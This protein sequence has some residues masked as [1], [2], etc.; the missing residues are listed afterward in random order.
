MRASP[1]AVQRLWAAAAAAAVVVGAAS[2]PAPVPA[3]AACAAADD[4]CCSLNGEFDA[5]LGACACFAPWTGAA[6]GVLDLLP[7]GLPQGYGMNPNLTSWGASLF[8]DPSHP[9]VTH[10][11]VAESQLGCSLYYWSQNL[12][13]S[14]AVS[15]AGPGAVYAFES[16]A[17][18]QP[19][20][21]PEVVSFLNATTGEQLFALFHIGDGNGAPAKNCSSGAAD[22]GAGA[23]EQDL[24]RGAIALPSSALTSTLHIASSPYGPWVPSPFPPPTCNNPAP[25]PHPNGSF[26]LLCDSSAL[27][28]SPHSVLGPWSRA[29]SVSA[30]GGVPGTYE[31]AALFIDARGHWH[32]LFHVYNVYGLIRISPTRTL[33]PR[34][35]TLVP[36]TRP[37]RTCSD[38]T[39]SCVN[40]TVSGHAFSR[41]GLVWQGSP[42]QPFG[43]LVRFADGSSMLVS[44]RERPKLLWD[45][46][47]IVPTHLVTAVTGGVS[48]CAWHDNTPCVNCK[49]DF[50]DFSL[51]QPLNLMPTS[52]LDRNPL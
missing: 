35:L 11:I 24:P 48:D 43:N 44:T 5:V 1:S 27:Y 6:C 3:S 8:V 36:H 31:D 25:L 52:H 13:C 21:N 50:W 40:S 14:H 7:A 26:F 41:D 46:A 15:R 16:V 33:S 34:F 32:A 17:V 18:A 39:P 42:E 12:R 51:V 49:Y 19:C 22:S 23:G 30:P 2:A 45:A 4:S 47:H 38:V 29:G 28:Y 37:A 10:M 9:D 20:A